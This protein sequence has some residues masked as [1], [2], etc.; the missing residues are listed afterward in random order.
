MD[1]SG[2]VLDLGCGIGHDGAIAQSLQEW[3]VDVSDETIDQAKRHSDVDNLKF[4]V[5]D[6]TG[7][8]D[9]AN[10]SF[11]LAFSLFCRT[12]HPKLSAPTFAK[13]SYLN[14]VDVS[15]TNSGLALN[16]LKYNDTLNIRVYSPEDLKN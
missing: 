2:H 16:E 12:C 11:D 4:A 15:Y 9:F 5:N 10:A 8:G 6:G 14:P 1:E 7:L 13:E 3:L